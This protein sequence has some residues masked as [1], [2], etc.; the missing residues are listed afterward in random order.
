L[1][2][3][4]FVVFV[5]V[6]SFVFASL[7][8]ATNVRIKVT[9]QQSSVVSGAR[10]VIYRE[11]SSVPVA[12]QNAGADGAVRFSGL[13]D[14]ASYRAHVA[15]P[16]FAPATLD[17][18]AHGEAG[19]FEV[20]LKVAAAPENVVVSATGTPLP[21][22]ESAADV[23]QLDA[24]QLKAMQPVSAAEAIRFMPGVTVSDAG[25]RGGLTSLFVRG[26]DSRYNKVYVD[27]VAVTDPGGTFDFGTLPMDQI[28]RVEMVRGAES[29]LYGS[30]A[31]T[32]VVQFFTRNG[33]TRTPELRFGADGGNFDTAHGYA[34]VA[35]ARGRFDYNLFGDQFNTS[36]Q[37]VNDDY[38]NSSQGVN[39]GVQLAP[40]AFFRFHA[41][42]SNSRTGLQ[43]FWNFNGQELIPPDTDQYARQNNFLSDATLSFSTSPRWQHRITA[44]EYNHKRLNRDMFMD[45]GRVSQDYGFNFDTPFSYLANINQAGLDYQGEYFARSWAR[46][47]FGYHFV[48]ENGYVGDETTPPLTHGLRRNHEVFAQQA[49]TWRRLSLIASGR[50]LH[51]EYFGNKGVPRVA[52][53]WMLLR[54][55]SFFSGTRLRAVYS[56]GIKEPRLEETFAG[57]AFIVP[58]PVLQPERNQSWEAGF[59]QNLAGTKYAV[60]GTYYHNTFKNL[61]TF[62]SDPMT[63]IGK[64]VNLD[65]A[66]AHGAEVEFHGRPMS[67]LQLDAAYTYTSTQILKAGYAIDPLLEAGRP[68]LRRP[69]NSG[70]VTATWSGTRWGA[71]VS[72][73]AVGRRTDSD[74]Y[75]LEPH[76]T[77]AAGYGRVDFGVWREINSRMTA[78][79][80]VQNALNRHYEE[81][82][83]YPALHAN[84][85]AGMRFRIGGE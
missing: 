1:R 55:G 3:L 74:F 16:A 62:S 26:G 72:A 27:G 51:N 68:L 83:G 73:V 5:F 18:R 50:F 76:V 11:K 41:R 37:G 29:S 28:D 13:Q 71:N 23:G 17:F 44:F 33:T 38:S 78:Y 85:R 58:N 49:F 79:V 67:R 60:V 21:A 14:G 40:S 6:F 43:G 84:F 48:D 75:G 34:S 15:A 63:F 25:Q 81:V 45:P 9:D 7:A 66:L 69:K 61:I 35:G 80:K 24:A 59:V 22:E 31:M 46:T 19:S 12:V 82:A 2:Q 30:D 54:G 57:G 4:R 64:Y 65:R 42:H 8:S 52:A 36:G 53:S 77:Y 10:V 32:S 70:V 56:E 47:T 39:L 20:E